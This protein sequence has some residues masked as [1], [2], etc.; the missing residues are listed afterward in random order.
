MA[1]KTLASLTVIVAATAISSQASGKSHAA[2]ETVLSTTD[3][4]MEAPDSN[5]P[6]SVKVCGFRRIELNPAGDR[7][8]TT[9]FAGTAQLWDRS[10][11]E[12]LKISTTPY[13]G[14]LGG[15]MIAGDNLYVIDSTGTLIRF[16]VRD[17][18]ELSRREAPRDIVGIMQVYGTKYALA[19][20]QNGPSTKY[21]VLDLEQGSWAR[22][23]DN[24]WPSW[25][26][27]GKVIGVYSVLIAPKNWQTRVVFADDKL[28]EMQAA[29]WCKLELNESL[30][31]A[32]DENGSGV[33]I[34]D[35]RTGSTKRDDLRT[36]MDDNSRI[37]WLGT[38]ERL[39]AV[40]CN[41]RSA[42]GGR[43]SP[44]NHCT[45]IDMNSKRQIFRFETVSYKV[46]SGR[47]PNGEPELRVA[48]SEDQVNPAY[49][50]M[51][52]S[53]DGRAVPVGPK[54]EAIGLKSL[55]GNLLI[56]MP[57]E[58]GRLAIMGSNGAAGSRVPASFAHCIP[59]NGCSSS[60]DK[61]VV[62]ITESGPMA[63]GADVALDRIR[64]F[65]TGQPQTS[66]PSP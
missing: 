38:V 65:S 5:S 8:L 46:A 62:A 23:W 17:G 59:D 3:C 63:T 21:G 27:A 50:V 2:S 36:E 22:Q 44:R 40:R 58:R 56:G 55:F 64:W 51:R 24:L 14:Y 28:T 34:T 52:V 35:I 53:L 25:N 32:P 57:G 15:A 18:R 39:L 11:R 42:P 41:L 7:L 31:I 48:V 12:L 1:V 26:G 30:C 4:V 10:G 29:K 49:H 43:G 66:H 13:F 60:Y 37:E 20:T 6:P 54:S 16:D 45:A 9:T 47:G 33:T 61:S 19:S